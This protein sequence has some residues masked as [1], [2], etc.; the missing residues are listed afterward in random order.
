MTRHISTTT[1][2]WQTTISIIALASMLV[3]TGLIMGTSNAVAASENNNDN[4]GFDIKDFKIRTFGIQNNNPFL[5]VEGTAGGTQPSNHNTIYGYV[6]KT[7]KGIFAV[8]SHFGKDSS[9]QSGPNDLDYHAHKITLDKNN[10]VSS[11]KET[12]TADLSGNTVKVLDTG[13]NKVNSVLTVKLTVNNNHDICVDK[14]FD[15]QS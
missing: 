13:A 1:T 6:F 10:C 8:V 14:V 4:H 9:E 2:K 5:K 3:T 11:L 7:D 12:G 15:S